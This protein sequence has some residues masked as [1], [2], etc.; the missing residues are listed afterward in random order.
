ML[1]D[2]ETRNFQHCTFV[3]KAFLTLLDVLNNRTSEAA[4]MPTRASVVYSG[5]VGRG[6]VAAFPL[7]N[8]GGLHVGLK[9]G[10]QR[11]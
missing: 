8:I 5:L 2:A 3:T 6:I 10:L 1:Y 4:I 11:Q 7:A 9:M